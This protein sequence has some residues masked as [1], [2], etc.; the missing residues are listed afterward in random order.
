MAADTI[1]SYFYDW[2]PFKKDEVW[3]EE[4]DD[5]QIEVIEDTE[6]TTLKESD[7]SDLQTVHALLTLKKQV[8]KYRRRWLKWE[9]WFSNV[10]QAYGG[11]AIKYGVFSDCTIHWDDLNK[12]DPWPDFIETKND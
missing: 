9:G 7:V 11:V 6:D 4:E 1:Y 5:L 12:T 8:E 3:L 2:R 10:R